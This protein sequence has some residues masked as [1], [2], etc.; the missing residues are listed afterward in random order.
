[1][2]KQFEF[3][4]Q[5]SF[6]LN[7]WKKNWSQTFRMQSVKR[8]K[9]QIK[10]WLWQGQRIKN[11]LSYHLPIFRS[12]YVFVSFHFFSYF[13]LFPY[14]FASF[15]YLFICFFLFF[16][17]ETSCQIF[18]RSRLI[19][20]WTLVVQTIIILSL[21]QTSDEMNRT[22]KINLQF[23]EKYFWIVQKHVVALL[24]HDF[25]LS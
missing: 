17:F 4:L 12:P 11:L 15:I 25:N 20:V 5:T 8:R 13:I 23:A 22:W 16:L 21:A 7:I 14:L 6:A 19:N 1:M 3:L 18:S 9:L 2:K 10:F 24:S